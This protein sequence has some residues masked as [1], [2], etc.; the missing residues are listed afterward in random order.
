MLVRGNGVDIPPG[1]TAPTPTAPAV[2]RPRVVPNQPVTANMPDATPVPTAMPS[3][4]PT[5]SDPNSM[6]AG[7]E[8]QI[9]SIM[10]KRNA[11]QDE[12][13]NGV[14]DDDSKVVNFYKGAK[15]ALQEGARSGRQDIGAEIGEILGGGIRNLFTKKDDDIIEKKREIATYDQQLETA[16]SYRD[17]NLKAQTEAAKPAQA[18][19]KIDQKQQQIDNQF[20]QSKRTYDRLVADEEGRNKRAGN[21]T[22]TQE[23][24]GYLFRTYPNDPSKPMEPIIDPRSGKQAF[25]PANVAQEITF[26]DGTKAFAKGGQIVAG[27]FAADRQAKQQAFQGDQNDKER[28]QRQQQFLAGFQLKVAND[29]RQ[30][31]NDQQKIG[32]WKAEYIKK[33]QED[34]K[35]E[36]IDQDTATQML[37]MIGQ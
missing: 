12:L 7:L 16:M 21:Q 32:Q 3:P 37:G 27:K 35:A 15:Y 8:S 23:V 13:N 36:K 31:G 20:E 22:K 6:N 17:K 14:E 28:A 2:T 4:M 24:D 26:D 1:I 19:A 9:S 10:A 18:Q 29:M 33:I 5:G 30:F 34:L 25:N 11:A